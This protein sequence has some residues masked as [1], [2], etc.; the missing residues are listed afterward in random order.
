MPHAVPLITPLQVAHEVALCRIVCSTDLA[1]YPTALF[2]QD[3]NRCVEVLQF[4]EL[5]DTKAKDS[6]QRTSRNCSVVWIAKLQRRQ[7]CVICSPPGGWGGTAAT[8]LGSAGELGLGASGREGSAPGTEDEDDG[9]CD[10]KLESWDR[11]S[12]PLDSGR[13]AV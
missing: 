11:G 2:I 7:K 13:E 4:T 10:D 1:I 5:A 8:E 6:A 9:D 12:F 3:W